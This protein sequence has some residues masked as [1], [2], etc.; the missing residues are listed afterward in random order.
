MKEF[1]EICCC[2][3]LAYSATPACSSLF[4]KWIE[5]KKEEEKKRKQN[6]QTRGKKDRIKE[7]GG[8]FV[9]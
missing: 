9:I 2:F 5:K 6:K 7:F 8:I 4:A 3:C 1:G